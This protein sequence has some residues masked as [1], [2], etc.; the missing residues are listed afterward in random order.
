MRVKLMYFTVGLVVL[1]AG[2]SSSQQHPDYTIF[3]HVPASQLATIKSV[4]HKEAIKNLELPTKLPYTITAA[5]MP[6]PYI[7][8]D[9]K[10]YIAIDMASATRVLELDAQMVPSGGSVTDTAAT[11]PTKL[12]DGTKAFY[13][14]NAA[15]SVLQWH[16]NNVWYEIFSS[17]ADNKPDLTEKALVQVADS[18]Q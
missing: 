12:S 5:H 11:K 4:I 15:A 17:T 16:K 10:H 14:H 18:F 7:T 1:L 8:P 13:G 3:Q 2:C 9:R 6:K